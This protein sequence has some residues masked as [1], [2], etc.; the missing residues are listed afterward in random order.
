MR[1]YKYWRSCADLIESGKIE[2]ATNYALEITLKLGLSKEVVEK[3]MAVS[4]KGFEKKIEEKMNGCLKKAKEEN[5]EALCLYYS[6]DNGWD[7]TMYICKDYSTENTSWISESRSWIDLG[8]TRGFSEIYKNTAES[9]FFANKISSA[10]CILLMFRTTIA[11]Y[12]VAQKFSDC[13]LKLCITAT[14]SDFVR[15]A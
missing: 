13:G 3:I 2:E 8:K 1:N 14:E 4:L 12:N 6:M 5:A 10:V 7:S 11:F 15:V 9:A